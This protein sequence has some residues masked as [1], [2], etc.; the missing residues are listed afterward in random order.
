MEYDICAKLNDQKFRLTINIGTEVFESPVG[1]YYLY[2]I[3]S[4]MKFTATRPSDLVSL[5]ALT[6]VR[7][8]FDFYERNVSAT[9]VVPTFF[10]SYFDKNN[11]F[12]K[13]VVSYDYYM[14]GGSKLMI[15]TPG[16]Y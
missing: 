7:Y 6:I 12:D 9:S 5:E 11:C 14:V 16:T 1:E 13:I 15:T 2:S 8:T 3:T 4:P 10:A